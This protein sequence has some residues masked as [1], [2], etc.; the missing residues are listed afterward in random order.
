MSDSD[1]TKL[2]VEEQVARIKAAKEAAKKA[3]AEKIASVAAAQSAP[4][5]QAAA[6][7]P[8]P[9]APVV[10]APEAKAPPTVPVP[11]PATVAEPA[12]AEVPPAAATTYASPLAAA[13]S[14]AATPVASVVPP[15]A[16]PPAPGSVE[17]KVAQI[18][19][20][21]AAAAEKS[22]AA[23]AAKEGGAPAASLAPPAPGSVEEKVA[24]IKAA[25]AA[26][27]AKAAG[28]AAKPAEAGVTAASAP[29][30]DSALSTQHS[31]PK[32]TPPGT[33]EAIARAAAA[34]E[35]ALGATGI[36]AHGTPA[37]KPAVALLAAA[38]KPDVAKTAAKKNEPDLPLP[39][40]PQLQP[41]RRALGF[42]SLGVAAWLIFFT[43]LA[44]VGHLF[45]RFMFP[46]VL[47]EGDP[48]FNAGRKSD[49]PESP[50]VYENFKQSQAVWI[51]RLTEE[52]QDRLVALSTVCTH[53]GCTPN[54][55]EAENK[56]KCPCHGSG[57]YMNGVNFE[58]PT[59]RP[60]ERYRIFI[61]TAGNI[62]VDKSKKF[63]QDL[64]QWDENQS[65]LTMS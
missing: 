19:A 42:I 53:L 50:H 12:A 58:G 31:G 63:R 15:Q 48:K 65:F 10:K 14:P 4:A 29:T 23:A 36:N 26:A 18:K 28:A 39:R 27:A 43:W 57:Y 64:Q 11:P 44:G 47:Y 30:Q 61:D 46:N 5:P 22:K 1:P 35:K 21:K 7:A 3:A 60:L 13:A 55:L 56:F 54:W 41:R 52:S 49:F 8:K 24:Q 2:S 16:P 33:P 25:K 6:P 34:H 17:E 37:N 62:I 40:P 32:T 51:V 59:P 20:A 38:A 9:A 45:L